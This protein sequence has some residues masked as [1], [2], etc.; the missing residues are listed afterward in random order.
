[1]TPIFDFNHRIESYMILSNVEVFSNGITM[2]FDQRMTIY[3]RKKKI[4]PLKNQKY[5]I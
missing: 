3:P 1:M 4:W 2:P 5:N